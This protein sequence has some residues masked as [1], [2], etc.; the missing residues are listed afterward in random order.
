MSV[1]IKCKD[2]WLSHSILYLL[3]THY[4]DKVYD[5]SE[6]EVD[7]ETKSGDDAC[8]LKDERMVDDHGH[9]K[10]GNLINVTLKL[11]VEASLSSVEPLIQKIHTEIRHVD[12]E[13]LTVVRQQ[14]LRL[15]KRSEMLI[16]FHIEGEKCYMEGPA[17]LSVKLAYRGVPG[18]GFESVL[19]QI[20]GE[21]A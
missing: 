20:W 2:K 16:Y 12:A 10:L 4:F 21:A 7:T 1:I 6:D 11:H 13:I 14:A 17:W 8:A 18:P 15:K 3:L 9:G 19:Q 5:F